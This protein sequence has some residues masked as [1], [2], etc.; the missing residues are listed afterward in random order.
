MMPE[1]DED[2]LIIILPGER[3]KQVGR[4]ILRQSIHTLHLYIKGNGR[5]GQ[6]RSGAN[7][8]MSNNNCDS[9]CRIDCRSNSRL[10]CTVLERR[11]P[12]PAWTGARVGGGI[13][14]VFGALG[15]RAWTSMCAQSPGRAW[16]ST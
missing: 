12:S 2:F 9:S 5:V 16:T 3:L 11:I 14:W 8:T 10:L 1:V 6:G 7:I 13:G 4:P 15:K